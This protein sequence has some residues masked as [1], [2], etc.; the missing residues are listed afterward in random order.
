M[1]GL[2]E[3]EAISGGFRRGMGVDLGLGRRMT[4]T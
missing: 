4:V 2:S 3:D 1:R